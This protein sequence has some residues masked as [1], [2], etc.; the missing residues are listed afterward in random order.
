[1]ENIL[2]KDCISTNTFSIFY[3]SYVEVA[4][5]NIV[6]NN[7][8]GGTFFYYFACNYTNVTIYVKIK[9]NN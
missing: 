1:M 4:M 7:V 8:D 5:Q 3:D 2:I 9:K 6:L